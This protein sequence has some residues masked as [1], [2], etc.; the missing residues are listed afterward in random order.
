MPTTQHPQVSKAREGA[1]VMMSSLNRQYICIKRAHKQASR[2]TGTKK[3][4]K[5]TK[6][7]IDFSTST[8]LSSV[9]SCQSWWNNSLYSGKL[10]YDITKHQQQVKKKNTNVAVF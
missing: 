9:R 10:S 8:A 4:E 3:K 5:K 6:Y 1:T 7:T 2:L